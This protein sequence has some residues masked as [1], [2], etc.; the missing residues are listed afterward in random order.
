MNKTKV[1]SILGISITLLTM[2]VT[3]RARAEAPAAPAAPPAAAPATADASGAKITFQTPIYDFG[4][5]K[6]GEPVKF[7]YVFTNTGTEMLIVSNVAPSCGCTTSGEW[8]RQVE[9]GKTGTI[10]IQFATVNYNGA[11]MKTITVSCNDKAQPSVLLQIKGTVWKPIE[12]NPQFAAVNVPAES[13]QPV[14][15]EVKIVNNTEEKLTLSAPESNNKSFKAE[16]ETVTPGKEFKVIITTVPPLES[17]NIQ[18]QVT[19]KSSS[20]EMPVINISVWGS[21]LAAV[22]VSP[23]QI[24]LPAGPLPAKQTASVTIH[25]NSTNSISLSDAAVDAKGVEVQITELQPGKMF[26]AMLSFPQGFEMVPGTPVNFSVKTTHA[27][28]PLLKVPVMQMPKLPTAQQQIVPLT[29][30]TPQAAVVPAPA[31]K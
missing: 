13:L 15:T 10:P 29:P 7:S 11:V 27:K 21:V 25:N 1:S 9:P 28:H 12:V 4:K 6:S 19:L 18:G 30:Q 14:K 24:M 23:G 8:T 2:A 31:V 3:G 26:N 5:A 22:S 20:A 17:G 16:L